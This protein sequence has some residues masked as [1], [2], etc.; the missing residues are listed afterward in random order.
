VDVFTAE[1]IDSAFVNTF[2]RYDLPQLSNPREDLDLA[3]YSIV[4]VL[5][6]H[7]GQRTGRQDLPRRA[8]GTQNRLHRPRR[9]LPQPA[10]QHLTRD[11]THS[12]PTRPP[13]ILR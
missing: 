2:A 8:M 10:Q 5:E 9:L 11:I 12:Q 1:G 7:L 3:S 13:I 6:N 4:K